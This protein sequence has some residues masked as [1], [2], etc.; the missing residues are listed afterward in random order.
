MTARDAFHLAFYHFIVGSL[1]NFLRLGASVRVVPFSKIPE[2]PCVMVSNHISH[3][4]PPLLSGY[5][6]RKIDWIAMAELFGTKWSKAGF[7]WLDVI[8][9]DRHGD[10]RQAL[11]TA[12]KRLE[13]GRM[14]GIFPEGGIRDGARSILSGAEM[15]EGAFLIAAKAGCPVVP[16]VILGSE[17]LYNRRNWLSWRRAKVYIAVGEPVLP[18]EGGRK[19]LRDDTAAALIRLKDRLVETCHLTEDDLPHSPQER[20]REP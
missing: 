13:A 8:P 20:M 5:L 15:R 11:R 16:V 4:D 18:A 7:T 1:K 9:V 3:F 17:R 10:D 2:G 6:P 19:Q 14:I 12:I